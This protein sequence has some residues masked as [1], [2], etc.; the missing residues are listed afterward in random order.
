MKTSS[1]LFVVLCFLVL[2]CAEKEKK[3]AEVTIPDLVDRELFFGNPDKIQVRISPDGKYFSYRAPVNNV[4]NI[5][6]APID[7]PEGAQPITHDTLRGIQGYQWSYKSGSILYAQDKGG[8]E[9]WHVHLVDVESKTDTD[10]TPQEEIIGADGK[11]LTD[12]NTGQIVRPRA[13]IMQVSREKP[14]EIL[15]QI[16][17]SD[18]S[19]MDVY[20]VDLNTHKMKLVLKDE[21]FLQIVADNNNNIR[22]ATRTNPE[23]GQIIYKFKKGSWEEYFR[24]PQEDMLSFGFFGFDKNNENAYMIDSRGRDKAALYALNLSTDEKKIIA[25]NEKSDI[26]DLLIHPT[27]YEVEAYATDYLR[28][29]WIPLTDD[30]KAD[31]DY[32]KGFKEGELSVYFRSTDDNTWILSYD[33]PQEFLKYYKYNRD[34]KKAELLVS[35]KQEFDDVELANMYPVEIE[36]RDG[37]KLVSYLTIPRELDVNGRTS[38]PA[39]TVL[40]VHGGPW[41]RDNY[42]FNSLHQ[43]L[44]NRGYVVL[45]TNFR[46]ST[47]FG[48]HFVNIAAEEWAGKM[49]DDLIDAVNWMVEE[50]IADKEKVA[51]MGGSYGGYATLVGLAYTPDV[52]ACGVDIV[53]PSNLTTLLNTIPPYWKSFRDVFVHHIGNPDTEEGATLLEERSPLNRVDSIVKPL[54]IGQGANDPRVKQAESDQIVKAMNEKQIP[55]T[56]VLYP[57]EGH[58]FA[59]PE[60]N[61]SFFA[62][63]EV[64]LA[65]H[66]GGRYQEIGDDFKGSSIQ[67]IDSGNLNGLKTPEGR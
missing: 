52:F 12:R 25:E 2:S 46:G 67:I 19:N 20:K 23:G 43:W 56:Y 41:G 37:L 32:L 55:V 64:F 21:A 65:Q 8:D 3:I 9:N 47:G 13:D 30:V 53:G 58:G 61:L 22:L 62:V 24:V 57:D 45:S 4:M 60:N 44:A 34:A 38:K 10:L 18:P 28:K 42:G 17:N 63:S 36:S 49:H 54:L 15:I 59:R 7:N 11:P 50:K 33:S 6:V 40:L 39:P 16:N 26:A 5:W 27:N 29:D 51:I 14:E 35:A 1:F 31:L 66:I 48:K